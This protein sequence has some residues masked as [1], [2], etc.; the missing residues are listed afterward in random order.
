MASPEPHKSSQKV[1]TGDSAGREVKDPTPVLSAS[2]IGSYTFCPEAWHL[3]RRGVSRNA[4]G[5]RNVEQGTLAHQ[6]IGSRADRVRGL[7]QMRRVLLLLV[8]A[9]LAGLLFQ[10]LIAGGLIRL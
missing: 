2:E 8:A 4:A 3:Q 10:V 9:L 1:R 7:E 5:S 6:N